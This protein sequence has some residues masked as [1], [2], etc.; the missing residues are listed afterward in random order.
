M[1]FVWLRL[2]RKYP[3]GGDRARFG[4]RCRCRTYANGGI[5]GSE[6]NQQIWQQNYSCCGLYQLF[7]TVILQ[8]SFQI[9][10]DLGLYYTAVVAVYSRNCDKATRRCLLHTHKATPRATPQEFRSHSIFSPS[11]SYPTPIFSLRFLLKG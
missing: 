8:G 5:I 4:R 11:A 3:N 1:Q 6:N 10:V 7:A 2:Q 9:Q